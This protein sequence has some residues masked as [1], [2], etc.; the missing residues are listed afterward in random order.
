MKKAFIAALILL[1]ANSVTSQIFE[2]QE[3]TTTDSTSTYAIDYAKAKELYL[4][5][6]DSKSYI[7]MM[8]VVIEF[9]AKVKMKVQ[10]PFKSFDKIMEWIAENIDKTDFKDMEEVRQIHVV[11]LEKSNIE[12]IENKE[13]HDFT[14]DMIIK[15]GGQFYIDLEMEMRRE[16]PEKFGV[17][18]SGN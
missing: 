13:F 9:G 2:L 7:E 16:Y 1:F 12:G 11:M 14:V 10:K 15:H 4:K 6:V 18:P 5:R 3:T 8:T 17:L